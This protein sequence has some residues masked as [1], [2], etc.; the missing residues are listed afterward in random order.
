MPTRESGKWDDITGRTF[1]VKDIDSAIAVRKKMRESNVTRSTEWK[2]LIVTAF[3]N[4][5]TKDNKAKEEKKI[6]ASLCKGKNGGTDSGLGI[7]ERWRID[8]LGALN[9][10]A[11]LKTD[12][13]EWFKDI[14]DRH[15]LVGC[16]KFIKK[17]FVI[18]SAENLAEMKQKYDINWNHP[19]FLNDVSAP[20]HLP[21]WKSL[22]KL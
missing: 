13:K 6:I 7:F 8:A 14:V 11:K 9:G 19:D 1:M 20:L 18:D 4:V 12:N 10:L 2:L 5:C 15:L 16:I 21:V 22:S 3:L 17:C